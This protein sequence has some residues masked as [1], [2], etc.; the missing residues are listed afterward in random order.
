MTVPSSIF[1]GVSRSVSNLGLALGALAVAAT[2]ISCSDWMGPE[3]QTTQQSVGGFD[4]VDVDPNLIYPNR[5]PDNALVRASAAIPGGLGGAYW[6]E[7]GKLVLLLT[8]MSKADDAVQTLVEW[9]YRDT[10]RAPLSATDISVESASYKFVNLVQWYHSLDAVRGHPSVVY[11]DIREGRNR[12]YVGVETLGVEAE[13]RQLINEEQVPKA[14]VLVEEV[15][16]PSLRSHSL[17]D[18][19]RPVAGGYEITSAPDE[20]ACSL[21][22]N[23]VFDL[24]TSSGKQGFVTNSHCTDTRGGGAE[25]D[26]RIWQPASL[27]SGAEVIG[28]E[29]RDPHFFDSSDE[30]SCPSDKLCRWSDAALIEYDDNADADQGFIA[31]A[32]WNSPNHTHDPDH[33]IIEDDPNCP[34]GS[35]CEIENLNLVKVGS[36]TGATLGNVTQTCVDLNA[37]T[38]HTYLCQDI[39]DEVQSDGNPLSCEGD[40]GAPV[41]QNTSDGAVLY[42]IHWGGSGGDCGSDFWFSR[43]AGVKAELGQDMSAEAKFQ[44]PH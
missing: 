9:Q 8:D 42:G 18:Y 38:L 28:N 23:V 2:M 34:L 33:P 44:T 27:S 14:A 31:N 25:T 32:E 40:S 11:T 3:L 13:L 39:A 19:W 24:D 5:G 16:R 4:G 12:I 26:D 37:T 7:P 29:V 22:F 20:F 43:I 35:D 41:F 1:G 36:R 30:P 17:Q 21:G 6:Q 10:I 15:E